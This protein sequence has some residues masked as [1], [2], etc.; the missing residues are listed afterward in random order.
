MAKAGNYT[1]E[2]LLDQN[3]RK[4]REIIR[5]LAEGMSVNRI[6]K[7]TKSTHATIENIQRIESQSISERKRSLA[8][9]ASRVA[10]SAINQIEDNLAKGKYQPS[11][12]PIV[13]GVA[14]DKLLL[15]TDQATENVHHS[16]HVQGNIFHAFNQFHADAQKIIQART[17]E[18]DHKQ[19]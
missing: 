6:C 11:H 15:L 16:V 4:Y 2:L 1:G 8:S 19:R 14:C 12:L 13:F 10:Q 5:L 17:I 7:V 18:N 9:V 3:P